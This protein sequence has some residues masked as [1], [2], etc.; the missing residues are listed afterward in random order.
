[1]YESKIIVLPLPVGACNS[2]S[3][4]LPIEGESA[5]RPAPSPSARPARTAARHT[6]P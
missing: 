3:F 5:A 4:L 2:T 6:R 1:M